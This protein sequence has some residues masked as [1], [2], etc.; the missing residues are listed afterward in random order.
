MD[1]DAVNVLDE[2]THR[3]EWHA[4]AACAGQ[5][6]D[7]FFPGTGGSVVAAK[8]LCSS[9]PVRQE[10]LSAALADPGTLG[11]WGGVSE[12]G[13]RELRRGSAA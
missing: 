2:V 1:P 9:C 10:C 5:S 12:R 6:V 8:A 4:R 11:I 7:I 13:R 3:P